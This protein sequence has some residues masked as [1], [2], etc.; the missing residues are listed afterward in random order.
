MEEWKIKSTIIKSNEMFN[1][2]K[3]SENFVINNV[4]ENIRNYIT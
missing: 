3:I 2:R 1:Y 4:H